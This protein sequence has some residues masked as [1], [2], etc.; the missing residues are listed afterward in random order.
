MKSPEEKFI[1]IMQSNGIDLVAMLPCDRIKNFIPLIHEGFYEIP[2]TREE[3]GIG[4]CAGAYMAG[5]RPMMVIQS[6]GL[7]NMINALE[8]LN[9]EC[10]IP[11]PIL[12]SWRGV[13]KEKIE[14]QEPLG[15]HL[16]A[17]LEGAEIKYTILD[18]PEKPYLL[19][20]AIKDAYENLRPHVILASP[21]VW[22]GSVCDFWGKQKPVMIQERSHKVVFEKSIPEP[23]MIR[24]DAISTIAPLLD[25]ELVVVNIGVPCKEMY[26]AKDRDLNFYM[27]GSMGLASSIGT[28]LAMYSD[29]KVVV[30]DGD[31]SLLMN[32]NTLVEAA[33]ISP[34]N[35]IIIGLDNGAYGSTGSQET[36][37]AN[38][39]DL[40]LL[41][42][43][44]GIENTM[45]VSTK[46][47]LE[48]AYRAAQESD[49][50]TFIHVILRSG[51]TAAPNIPMSPAEATRRFM[52][53]IK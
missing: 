34:K 27:F 42:L 15:E 11:L 50:F 25:D 6:T 18:D 32:P 37:T 45:K 46:E 12:A 47:E 23:K 20:Y 2:L 44:C 49:K 1:E 5:S 14:A 7:G 36:F 8:S 17:I 29:R 31:G 43:A 40:E 51:N 35:L 22:E 10:D 21:K 9:V 24:N 4:I 41:A 28:G 3:N 33:R 13:Y 39:L 26:A 16:P 52:D 19:D 48:K 30:L 38:F 53:A